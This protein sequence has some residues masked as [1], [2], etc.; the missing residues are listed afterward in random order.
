MRYSG[1][2]VRDWSLI[3]YG[4]GGLQ[5]ER[6]P[7]EVL[8]ERKWGADKVSAMRKGGIQSF[9]VFFML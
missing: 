4:E 8:P 3:I 1:H 5:N 2:K 9:G 7:R 6:G